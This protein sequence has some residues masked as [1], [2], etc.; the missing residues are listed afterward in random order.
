VIPYL[1]VHADVDLHVLIDRC[2]DLH[3]AS[4]ERR[5]AVL[6]HGHLP[7]LGPPAAHLARHQSIEPR[8]LHGARARGVV[9]RHLSGGTPRRGGGRGPFDLHPCAVAAEV[10][11][12]RGLEGAR[13]WASGRKEPE[14]ERREVYN[15]RV[16]GP[17]EKLVPASPTVQLPFQTW[18]E[19]YCSKS[20]EL[21]TYQIAVELFRKCR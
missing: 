2:V 14:E 13:V 15:P 21:S 7:E 9:H 16:I 3:P 17:D 6:R 20:S 4:L 5:E 19:Q 18:A 8:L 12:G 11:R 1:D 10:G